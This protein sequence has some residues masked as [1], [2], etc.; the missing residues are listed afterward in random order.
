MGAATKSAETEFFTL[1]CE[2]KEQLRVMEDAAVQAIAM[3]GNL[4]KCST[5]TLLPLVHLNE[6]ERSCTID[7]GGRMG[8]EMG[9]IFVSLISLA[10]GWGEF[11][12]CPNLRSN[13]GRLNGSGRSDVR[14]N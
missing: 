10:E 3:T 8:L 7:V 5:L 12:V 4:H 6:K 2:R 1:T 13:R 9:F 14:E 11:L